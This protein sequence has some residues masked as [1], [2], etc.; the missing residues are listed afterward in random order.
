MGKKNKFQKKIEEA[1]REQDFLL[2][3]ENQPGVPIKEIAKNPKWVGERF[4]WEK[5]EKLKEERWILS[6]ER[7][8][9]VECKLHNE[10]FNYMGNPEEELDVEP[11]WK[12]HDECVIKL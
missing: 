2:D 1:E 4:D 3:P 8:G 7:P 6:K 11:C 10:I 5:F 12:C 9:Y